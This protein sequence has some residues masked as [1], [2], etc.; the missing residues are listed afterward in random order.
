LLLVQH[1]FSILVGDKCSTAEVWRQQ[2]RVVAVVGWNR[3]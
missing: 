1:P 3:W 2:Q